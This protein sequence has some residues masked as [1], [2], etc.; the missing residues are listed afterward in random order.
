M[1][2]TKVF[3]ITQPKDAWE[4]GYA[5]MA[6]EAEGLRQ[7]CTRRIVILS[8]RTCTVCSKGF[9]GW[10]YHCSKRCDDIASMQEDEA[11]DDSL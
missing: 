8:D 6:Y 5:K 10:N 9:I 4:R 1:M 2:S 11:Q 3:D 7:V